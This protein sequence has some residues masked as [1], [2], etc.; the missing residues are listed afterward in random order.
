MAKSTLPIAMDLM[1]GHEGGYVNANTDRGGPMKYGITHKTL[2]AHRG[3]TA[4]NPSQVKAMTKLE[5]EEIYRRSYWGQSGGDV[6]PRGWTMPRSIL[7]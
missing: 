5:A 4:V 3:I 1:F 6:L 7:V 2:A